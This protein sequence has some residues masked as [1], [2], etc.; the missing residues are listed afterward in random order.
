MQQDRL[1]R[2]LD[3]LVDWQELILI[4]RGAVDIGVHLDGIGTIRQDPLRLLDRL[5][6]RV[7][8]QRGGVADEM[9][10]MLGHQF[11]EN[12]IAKVNA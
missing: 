9:V 4:D 8:G 12:V 5:L 10:G 3:D 7:H 1:A 6:G 11:G 2:F